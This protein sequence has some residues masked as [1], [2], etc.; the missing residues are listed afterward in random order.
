MDVYFCR[1]F[2]LDWGEGEEADLSA[3]GL[4][5]PR[6]RVLM[7]DEGDTDMDVRLGNEAEGG[8]VYLL[9]MGVPAVYRVSTETLENLELELDDLSKPVAEAASEEA[10]DEVEAG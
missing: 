8:G 4:D 7:S 6:M 3:Y 9:R 2:V 5:D 1:K 10:D